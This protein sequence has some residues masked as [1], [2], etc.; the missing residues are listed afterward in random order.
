MGTKRPRK[1]LSHGPCDFLLSVLTVSENEKLVSLDDEIYRRCNGTAEE[2]P[3]VS[4]AVPT[5]P[6]PDAC[7]MEVVLTVPN[8]EF[9]L[10]LIQHVL[11][12]LILKFKKA[13]WKDAVFARDDNRDVWT[14]TLS[15]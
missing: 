15:A 14:L 5:S 10:T 9:R 6:A 7:L 2:R 11:H 12:A 3:L 13:G 8:D 4:V 1:D